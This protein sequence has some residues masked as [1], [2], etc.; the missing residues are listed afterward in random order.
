LPEP[1]VE[2]NVVRGERQPIDP[3]SEVC[4]ERYPS[5]ETVGMGRATTEASNPTLYLRLRIGNQRPRGEEIREER[6]ESIAGVHEGTLED[7]Q[8]FVEPAGEMSVGERLSEERHPIQA[9]TERGRV[10]F[11]QKNGEGGA[12]KA[13]IGVL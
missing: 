10:L 3:R 7:S 11:V 8:Q 6:N 4:F 5:T 2:E 13:P 12:S 9:V 1:F